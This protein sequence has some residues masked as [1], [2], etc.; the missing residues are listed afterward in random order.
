MLVW[1]SALRLET[2]GG[3]A[4]RGHAAL[5]GPGTTIFFTAA[6]RARPPTV[7]PVAGRSSPRLLRLVTLE[8]ARVPFV[9][10]GSRGRLSAFEL[11]VPPSQS[12]PRRFGRPNAVGSTGTAGRRE[13]AFP[14]SETDSG[15]QLAEE[16]LDKVQAV[17]DDVRRVLVVAERAQDAAERARDDIRKVNLLVVGSAIV[18]AIL[19]L[20][21]R[22]GRQ[23]AG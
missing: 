4:R 1:P 8:M 18:L 7:S 11:T 16:R 10:P 2:Q 20:I 23:Q 14:M 19:V 5:S 22:R 17:L 13:R 9:P 12:T 21:S 3:A 15:L 6:I